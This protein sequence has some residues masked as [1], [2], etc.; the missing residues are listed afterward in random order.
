MDPAPLGKVQ[1]SLGMSS[2][3]QSQP[4]L[5]HIQLRGD[6]VPVHPCAIADTAG[7]GCTATVIGVNVLDPKAEWT[8]LKV[9][10]I[11]DS[12]FRVVKRILGR[13]DVGDH[14]SVESSTVALCAAVEKPSAPRKPAC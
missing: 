10:C 1:L 14:G 11:I 5:V 4:C 8:C 13:V 12:A 6:R 3:S 7:E 2:P 9:P